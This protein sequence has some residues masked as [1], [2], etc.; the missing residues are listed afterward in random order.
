[1]KQ[2]PLTKETYFCHWFP[3][4]DDNCIQ[5]ERHLFVDAVIPLKLKFNQMKVNVTLTELRAGKWGQ[6]GLNY[7]PQ[8][9]EVSLEKFC[10]AMLDRNL[11]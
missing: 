5:F 7:F 9:R 11:N 6:L 1:L 8:F 2:E 3:Y 10:L 4:F